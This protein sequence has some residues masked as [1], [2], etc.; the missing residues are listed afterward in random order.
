MRGL[1]KTLTSL[2]ATLPDASSYYSPAPQPLS[3]RAD[4]ETE[5]LYTTLITAYK[6]IKGELGRC[7]WAG[8]LG[9]MHACRK[10]PG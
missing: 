1:V 8:V 2:P 9:S 7:G 10:I 6:G 5:N 4:N 3:V